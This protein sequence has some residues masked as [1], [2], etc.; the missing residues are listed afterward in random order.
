MGLFIV[1][2]LMKTENGSFEISNN[3]TIGHKSGQVKLK[4]P[5]EAVNG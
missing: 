3:S 1:G 2:E 4:F 5:L